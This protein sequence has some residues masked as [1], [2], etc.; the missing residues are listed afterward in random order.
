MEEGPELGGQDQ[1]DDEKRD[2][3]SKEQTLEGAG[4]R[5]R[6]TL[7]AES[8]TGVGTDLRTKA[9]LEEVLNRCRRDHRIIGQVTSDVHR[10]LVMTPSENSRLFLILDRSNLAEAHHTA[11]PGAGDRELQCIDRLHFS[12]GSNE[13]NLQRNFIIL[14]QIIPH[15]HTLEKGTDEETY[16]LRIEA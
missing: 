15:V 16:L 4:G 3:E 10:A 2:P 1:V 8:R 14:A 7:E 13:A 6:F 11:I 9:L 12:L 5:F